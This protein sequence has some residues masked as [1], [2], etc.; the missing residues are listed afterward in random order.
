[1]ADPIKRGTGTTAS[2][3]YLAS[4][5]EN[6][7][8]N[9]WS[10]PNAFIDKRANGNG[11]GKELCDLLVICGD[12]VIIFSDKTI[13]WP[14]GP[15]DLSWK[16]WFRRAIEKSVDQI[17][18]AERWLRDFPDRIFIDRECR[19]R[20]PL[21]LPPVDR[22]RVHR[23]V[24]ALG[25]D[26][27][28]KEFFGGGSGSFLLEP[29]IVKDDH[30]RRPFYIGD[31]DPG[32][33]YVHVLNQTS[34][35]V[36]LRELDTIQDL[37]QYLSA[38]ETF[39]RSGALALAAG[40]EELLGYYL[41][42]LDTAGNHSFVQ[43]DGT[44]FDTS[45]PLVFD[46]GIYANLIANPQYVAKKDAD[47]VS[48]LWDDLIR[49]FTDHLV[50]GTTIVPDGEVVDLA[51]HELG[52]REMALLTRFERRTNATAVLG[53]LEKAHTT[54]RYARLFA[55]TAD[56]GVGKT[57]FFFMTLKQ[58]SFVKDYEQYRL[59]RRNMMTTYALAFLEANRHLGRIV[60]I[61][62]EPP[63]SEAGPRRGS[64]DLVYAAPTEWN[65]EILANLE[66]DKQTLGI[67]AKGKFKTRQFSAT[68][69]PD[70]TARHVTQSRG[71]NRRSRR[72]QKAKTR[73][74]GRY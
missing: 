51:Y 53:V 33:P 34:L 20:L 50:A 10:Y 28:C 30:A 32:A 3:R 74:A 24:V 17:R 4:L 66:A 25:A 36:L 6:A 62:M 18:G 5:A 69:Y 71:G 15:T 70:A 35:D 63:S 64:E 58:P 13:A 26:A 41:K 57:G 44:P 40:E 27:A 60:G 16:R 23:I 43:Q 72:A 39:V 46:Q 11:D 49:V 48:Y 19:Q 29:S 54:D 55:P 2:E 45:N 47:R 37:T 38:K 67:M 22:M 14:E 52:V 12:D 7:F 8:L 9:L 56:A 68:E 65:P 59:V 42:V 1:M 31:I 73:R 21:P 61:G